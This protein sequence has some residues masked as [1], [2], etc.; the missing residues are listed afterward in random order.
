MKLNKSKSHDLHSALQSHPSGTDNA[1]V[2]S[3][4]PTL[5]ANVW[6]VGIFFSGGSDFFQGSPHFVMAKNLYI[7]IYIYNLGC[8][9]AQ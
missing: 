9:P 6:G 3:F 7:Y 4:A 2:A 1:P 8:P 5:A